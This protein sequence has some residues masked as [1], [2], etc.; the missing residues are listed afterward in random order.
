[1]IKTKIGSMALGII[2]GIILAI[3]LAFGVARRANARMIM[4]DDQLTAEKQLS[5]EVLRTKNKE[6][7]NLEKHIKDLVKSN[8]GLKEDIKELEA[9]PVVVTHTEVIIKGE[10]TEETVDHFP[11]EWDYRNANNLLV[12]SHLYNEDLSSFSATTYDLT[13]SVQNLIATIPTGESV[14]YSTVTV[15]SSGDDSS[16]Q[17]V[18][19][20][21]ETIYE[22]QTQSRW[23]WWAPHID[24]GI[25]A[26]PMSYG[27]TLGFSPTAIGKTKD[28]NTIRL[29]HVRGVVTND[30]NLHVGFDP[31]GI[32]VFKQINF[33]PLNDTWLWVGVDYN[34]RT[35]GILPAAAVTSTF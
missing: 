20:S 32:P 25:S 3:G 16:V 33:I 8:D 26:T 14:T 11:E 17:L 31:G 15:T 34:V 18:P 21:V 24:G 9:N 4:L 28:D 7:Y 2:V 5:Q 27:P 30:E 6:V 12:A 29:F 10:T 13:V 1:M 23:H 35:G 19:K 22:D